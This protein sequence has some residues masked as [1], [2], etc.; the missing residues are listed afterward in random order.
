MTPDAQVTS[1][2]GVTDGCTGADVTSAAWSA[3]TNGSVM[4][5]CSGDTVTSCTSSVRHL[6]EVINKHLPAAS[7]DLEEGI[8]AEYSHSLLGGLGKHK[9]AIQ[10]A[11]S[12]PTGG[13]TSD[14]AAS[15]LLRSL[16]ASRETVIR[17]NVYNSRN[18]YYS[19]VQSSLLTPP[20]GTGDPYKEHFHS[21]AHSKSSQSAYNSLNYPGSSLSVAMATGV[22]DGYSTMTPPSSVSPQDKYSASGYSLEQFNYGHDPSLPLKPQAYPL[23][24]HSNAA[25]TSFDRATPSDYSAYYGQATAGLTAYA[26]TAPYS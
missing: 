2:A 8:R 21:L 5:P 17:S 14:M 24:A 25:M 20:G 9:S 19:D 7:S 15:N 12:S 13:V 1:A 3:A 22:H 10:W 4:S 11:G 26:P 16:Y 18:H 6:E 23:A